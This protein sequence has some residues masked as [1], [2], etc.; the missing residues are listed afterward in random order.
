MRPSGVKSAFYIRL[1]VALRYLRT[2][3]GLSLELQIEA[4]KAEYGIIKLLKTP[5]LDLI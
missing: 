4:Q 3:V 5:K 1:L 2:I